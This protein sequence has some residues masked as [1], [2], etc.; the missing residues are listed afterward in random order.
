[1]RES[2]HVVEDLDHDVVAGCVA[3]RV[4]LC[5]VV[6]NFVMLFLG[7]IGA[8]ISASLVEIIMKLEGQE[9]TIVRMFRL[10][11]APSPSIRTK[12]NPFASYL[13]LEAYSEFVI[14]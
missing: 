11:I 9:S 3:V 14:C 6:F 10:T 8:A 2:F 4:T 12:T 5:D 7:S 13:L 1:M